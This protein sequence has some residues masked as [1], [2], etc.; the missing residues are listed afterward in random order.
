MEY[1]ISQ[2]SPLN[3]SYVSRCS[4]SMPTVITQW[5]LRL[6]MFKSELGPRLQRKKNIKVNDD[7]GLQSYHYDG[8]QGR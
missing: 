6:G 1:S 2:N 7:L 5:Q 4:I 8:N 3:L